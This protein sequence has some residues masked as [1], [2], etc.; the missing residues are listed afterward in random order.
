MASFEECALQRD[1]LLTKKLWINDLKSRYLERIQSNARELPTNLEKFPTSIHLYIDYYSNAYAQNRE[2]LIAY[3]AR[4]IFDERIHGAS[5]IPSDNDLAK[6]EISVVEEERLLDQVQRRLGEKIKLANEKIDLECKN[7][8]EVVSLAGNN[9]ELVTEVA[10]LEAELES[11][12]QALEEREQKERDITEQQTRELQIVHNDLLRETAMCDEMARE[13][14]RLED[15]LTQLKSE[16]QRRQMTVLDSQEQQKIVERWIKTIAPVVS[17]R[18]EG[19][20]LVFTLGDGVGA[21]SNR[22]I[23]AK[24]N[25]LGKVEDVRTDDGRKLPAVLDHDALMKLLGD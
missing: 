12:T 7:Y 8:E 18:V 17:A 22:R 19:N 5:F 25:E 9:E 6:L 21:L 23:L 11:L 4:K 24:F 10:E 16:E 15:R 13:H 20:T 1:E 3:R 14:A 2:A